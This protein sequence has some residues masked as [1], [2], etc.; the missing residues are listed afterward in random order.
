MEE[1]PRFPSPWYV[2]RFSDRTFQVLD[3]KGLV[4]AHVNFKLPDLTE[5]EARAIAKSIARLPELLRTKKDDRWCLLD[6]VIQRMI[7]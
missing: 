2:H 1:R 4:L 6:P 7:E 5:E 3:A